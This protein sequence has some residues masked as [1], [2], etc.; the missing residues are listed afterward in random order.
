MLVWRVIA[1]ADVPA[2]GASTE[3]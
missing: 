2:F 1:A 3:V